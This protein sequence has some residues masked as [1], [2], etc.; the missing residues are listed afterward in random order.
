MNDAGT[1][2]GAAAPSPATA[3]FSLTVPASWF[4][5][6]LHSLVLDATAGKI[7]KQAY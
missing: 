2:P 1:S 4:E 5:L 6:D 3:A 7:R